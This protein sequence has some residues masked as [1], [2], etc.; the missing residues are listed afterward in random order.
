[1]AVPEVVGYPDSNKTMPRIDG[2]WQP[3][4]RFFVPDSAKGEG[5]SWDGE[6]GREVAKILKA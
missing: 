6:D 2:R 1:M 4:S 3:D 5:Q